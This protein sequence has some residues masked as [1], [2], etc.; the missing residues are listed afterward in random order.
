MYAPLIIACILILIILEAFT[1]GFEYLG[2]TT[3]K[4]LYGYLKHIAQVALILASFLFGH[5]Y[6]D[7]IW[8]WHTLYFLSGWFLLHYGLFDLFYVNISDNRTQG[9]TSVFD[10]I[11]AK[12]PFL[13]NVILRLAAAF[14][15]CILVL[16]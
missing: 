8:Q 1:D 7:A 14:A 2:W 13:N 5:Y 3:H 9:S 12:L 10:W 11:T 6:S 15:G 16:N 4:K